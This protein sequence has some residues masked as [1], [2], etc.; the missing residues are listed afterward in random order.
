MRVL[1]W[2]VQT[3][4]T[5]RALSATTF[6]KRPLEQACVA[7][8]VVSTLCYSVHIK[9]PPGSQT[10]PAQPQGPLLHKSGCAHFAPSFCK[11]KGGAASATTLN[12]YKVLKRSKCER[13]SQS[14]ALDQTAARLDIVWGGGGVLAVRLVARTVCDSGA[15]HRHGSAT[16][17]CFLLLLLLLYLHSHRRF[18]WL[19]CVCRLLA[20]VLFLASFSV[21]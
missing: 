1:F 8:L 20:H 16:L 13:V 10:Q 14:S 2:L 11:N 19:C 15:S 12:I 4:K 3:C 7:E 18:P 5:P 6:E 9:T 17:L 21:S